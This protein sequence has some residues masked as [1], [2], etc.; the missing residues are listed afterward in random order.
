MHELTITGLASGGEGIAKLADGRVAF[1]QGGF[2]GDVVS[3]RIT[4]EKARVVFADAE[5]LISPSAQRKTAYDPRVALSGA[6]W[7]G[8]D[9]QAQLDAKAEIV[10]QAM[11]RIARLEVDFGGITGS[12]E[13]LAYRHRARF[14][15]VNGKV[16][17]FARG[18]H[19]LLP[20]TL[21]PVI[22]PE[23]E[24]A[25]AE[26]EDDL[27]SE[28]KELEIAYSKR[29]GRA[30]SSLDNE[31]VVRFDHP[32]DRDLW[33]SASVFTQA[34]P[35]MNALMIAAVMAEL[36]G[37]S[38]LELHAGIGNFSVP[39]ALA[40][41]TVRAVELNKEASAL[42][43][44]SAEGLAIESVAAPDAKAVSDAHKFDVVVMDPPRIGA[45]EASQ[46]LA[47][48]GPRQIIY[49]SCDPATLAR[50]AATLTQGGYTLRTLRS[51]DMFP[52]TPHVESLAVFEK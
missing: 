39:M 46:A 31:D 27:P 16:G 13:P 38:V 2:P 43:Q 52:Q 49:I 28:I 26:L 41:R 6:P 42:C 44:R 30:V 45:K 20:R 19:A 22:W 7:M 37:T 1:V 8:L 29:D 32:S 3:A 17:Y 12:P 48:R 9:Y 15:V 40:G 14:H 36:K 51:F 35:A 25:V 18:S 23:L 10:K 24:A 34:N 11:S 4:Q 33:F 21:T 50:D 5:H 47:K